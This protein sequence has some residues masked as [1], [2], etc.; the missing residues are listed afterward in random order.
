[1][2]YVGAL[3]GGF[4]LLGITVDGL[5]RKVAKP[6]KKFP[7][8]RTCGTNMITAGLPKFMPGEVARHLDKY[9]LPTFIASRFICP[10][11][12]YQLWFIPKLGNTDEPF[13][14][15]EQL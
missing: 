4:A 14:L 7:W 8:C 3:L 11:G 6:P 9:G 15:R 10:K 12:H 1:M 5:L 2:D 13:F